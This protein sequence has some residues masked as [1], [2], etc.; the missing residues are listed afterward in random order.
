MAVTAA[1]VGFGAVFARGGTAIGDSYVAVAEVVD[2]NFSGTT[3][4][5]LDASNMDSP[6]GHAEKV[7]GMADAGEWTF[8]VNYNLDTSSH[9]T[10]QTDVETVPQTQRYWK[11]TF[12]PASAS[13][14]NWIA[15]GF[16]SKLVPK[17]PHNG[18]Q[19]ASVTISLSGKFT[20][21]G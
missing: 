12:P 16:V 6:N 10:L 14:G 21:A 19:R 13:Q 3:V 7:P 20:R 18:V 4:S 17:V 8:D 11:L 15:K 5:V 1:V 2:F 9:E